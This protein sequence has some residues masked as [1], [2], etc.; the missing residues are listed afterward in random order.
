MGKDIPQRFRRWKTLSVG[1]KFAKP[2]KVAFT[3]DLDV[4]SIF[5]AAQDLKNRIS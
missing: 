3:H 4:L 2:A 5:N 1:K